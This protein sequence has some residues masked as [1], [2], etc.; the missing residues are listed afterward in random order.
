MYTKD[1]IKVFAI[2]NN[3]AIL[4]VFKKIFKNN[5]IF[6]FNGI[7]VS[8]NDSREVENSKEKDRKIIMD[9]LMNETF[10]I[11]ILD[12]L[13]RDN[14]RIDPEIVEGEEFNGIETVLSLEIA[15][16]LKGMPDKQDFLPVIVSSSD[17]C[18]NYTSF[19]EMKEQHS[20]KVPEDAVFISKPDR[21]FEKPQYDN[22][23]IY[24]DTDHP[25]CNKV[26]RNA[27]GCSQ[28]TCFLELLTKYYEEYKEKNDKE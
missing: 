11:L 26:D 7:R 16:C 2:E 13:L 9:T 21:E 4:N 24:S 17:I 25:V 18:D 19:K 12:L 22:C 23:P 6:E 10:D 5:E 20:D 3:R 1:K 8:G 27:G 28:K 15:R 14:M